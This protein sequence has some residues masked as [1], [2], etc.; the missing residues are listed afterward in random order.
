MI[1]TAISAYEAYS[2][3]AASATNA[4]PAV[5]LDGG[6]IFKDALA[7]LVTRVRRGI[8]AEDRDRIVAQATYFS[9]LVIL[10]LI[11][12]QLIGPRL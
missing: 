2:T 7:G 11:V 12:W 8:K 4:L 5:P 3:G 10:A 1:A 6:Y 9:A